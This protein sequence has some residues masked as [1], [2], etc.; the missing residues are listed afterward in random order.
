M[1]LTGSSPIRSLHVLSTLDKN[2][3]GPV[4]ATMSTCKY[5]NQAGH[6]AEVVATYAPGDEIDYLATLYPEVP[7]HTFPRSFP[8]R[9]ANSVRMVR[10][11]VKELPNY[12][13]V[14]IHGIFTFT[15]VHAARICRRTRTPYV[16]RPHGSLA[17]VDLRKHATLKRFVGPTFVRPMLAG[18]RAA[19]LTALLEA[20]ELVTYGAHVKGLVVPGAVLL[21]E[22]T[23][24]G[25]GFRRRHKIPTDAL[26]VLFMGRFHHVKG[27]QFLIPALCK[28]RAE[29]PRLWFVMAGSGDPAFSAR[30]EAWIKELNV[31][32]ITTRPGF[33]A[34]Q[35]KL[36]ALAAADV[37]VMPSL[38]ENFGSVLVEAMQAGLPLVLSDGIYIHKDIQAA[39]AGLVCRPE[40]SS[41]TEMLRRLLGSER[42]RRAMSDCGRHLASQRFRPEASTQLL[43]RTYR[44]LLLSQ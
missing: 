23:G 35:D 20:Q 2:Y 7:V 8:Q 39:G 42:E 11:L 25:L 3:G 37:F 9:Y 10:W 29:F 34:G 43:V 15:S 16:I 21:P 5:L 14:D 28:L 13:I 17:R 4:L 32:P 36:D 40:T 24:D 18:A 6:P 38:S 44:D 27:L 41:V 33:L 22:G 26:V 1:N 19:L 30:V 31:L 12:D